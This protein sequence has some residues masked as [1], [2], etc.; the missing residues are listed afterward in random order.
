MGWAG[1]IVGALTR[2][3]QASAGLQ[4]QHVPILEQHERLAHR[5]ARERAVIGRPEQVEKARKRTAR[6]LARLEQ[7]EA[8]LEPKAAPH[9]IVDPRH[10]DGASLRASQPVYV[11]RLPALT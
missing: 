10:R 2:D 6:R 1:N 8:Q 3:E 5:L 7:A 11:D 4:G 9:P